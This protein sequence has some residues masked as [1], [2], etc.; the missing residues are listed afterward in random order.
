VRAQLD[1]TPSPDQM[2]SGT[3]SQVNPADDHTFG[4]NGTSQIYRFQG[5]PDGSIELTN[6]TGSNGPISNASYS[7]ASRLLTFNLNGQINSP[8]SLNIDVPFLT[9][10]SAFVFK[11]APNSTW[12]TPVNGSTQAAFGAPTGLTVGG[13]IFT[14]PTSKL[15]PAMNYPQG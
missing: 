15:Y 1:R 3:I 4:P 10:D 8:N 13:T 5:W 2:I 9:A 11:P 6:L 14:E 7:P 12:S